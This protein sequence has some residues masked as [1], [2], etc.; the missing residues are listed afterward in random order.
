VLGIDR[1]GESGK[2]PALF[3]HFGFTADNVKHELEE[4]LS[5]RN[6]D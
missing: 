4:L 6:E 1:Y 5:L 3:S 2:G